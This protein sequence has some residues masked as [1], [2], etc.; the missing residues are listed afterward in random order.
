MFLP[1]SSKNHKFI[2][3]EFLLFFF[4]FHCIYE[5]LTVTNHTLFDRWE[6]IL[7]RIWLLKRHTKQHFAS[8]FS[9]AQKV[10]ILL[11]DT[12]LFLIHSF[13]YERLIKIGCIQ[14]EKNEKKKI[15][16]STFLSRRI[17]DR[18]VVTLLIH[19]MV[20]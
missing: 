8:F 11:K 18:Y 6:N 1:S 16:H 3:P 13:I 10:R 7:F 5:C 2:V 19:H 15:S 4:S 20:F 12:S 17:K 9:I 14:F